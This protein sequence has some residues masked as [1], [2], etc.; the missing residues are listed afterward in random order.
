MDGEDLKD[1][2]EKLAIEGTLSPKQIEI[3]RANHHKQQRNGKNENKC[4]II[5]RSHTSK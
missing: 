2:I 1:N 4:T 5:T 3:I